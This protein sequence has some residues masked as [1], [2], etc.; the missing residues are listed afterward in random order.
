MVVS[1]ALNLDTFVRPKVDT[2]IL[3]E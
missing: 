1:C 2:Y 3:N